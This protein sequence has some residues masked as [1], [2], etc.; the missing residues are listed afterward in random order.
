MVS[1]MATKRDYYEILG[2]PRT[3]TAKEIATAYR[4]L[5]IKYHPDSNKDDPTAIEKFKEAAEAYE[6]L[7]DAEKKARYDQYGH[8]GVEAAAPQ[9]NDVQDI[10]EAFGDMFGGGFFGD[11][12]G[13]GRRQRR[14]RRGEDIRVDV[15]LD[16]EEAATG[17]TK[18]VEFSRSRRCEPCQGT[19]NKAGAKREPCRRCGGQ[20]QVVQ[21]AG[22]LRVQTTCPSCSGAGSIVTNPCDQC[23]GRGYTA[24]KER[25]DVHI[26]AGV[27]DDNRVRLTGAGEP[28]PDGGS[29]GD[30]YCFISIRRHRLFQ[31]DGNNLILQL[32]ISY[33][34][35]ALGA[36][37]EVPTLTGP[38]QLTLPPGT[39]SGDVFRV[40]GHGM[41]ETR[42]GRKGDLLV[43]TYIEVPKKLTARQSELLRELAELEHV[44]VTPQR[45]SFLDKLKDYFAPE[46]AEGGPRANQEEE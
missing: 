30:C 33:S 36:T 3:A 4:K 35:A 29:P 45:K 43:Q 27:D 17:V 34:Q 44:D 21:S 10:F 25:I 5:A 7:S 12:F 32:P 28:S 9:F 24:G 46:S 16:L 14:A 40:A 8:A 2:V 11:L 38:T 39:Q 18:K 1:N 26:P 42:G 41:P 37:I 19:G 22:I 31:R 15:V 20:G 13:G 6:I 23:R